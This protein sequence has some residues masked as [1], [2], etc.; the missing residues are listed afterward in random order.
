MFGDNDKNEFLLYCFFMSSSFYSYLHNFRF[1][2]QLEEWGVN[3]TELKESAITQRIIGWTEDWEKE[4]HQKNRAVAKAMFTNKY[5]NYVFDHADCD[6]KLFMLVR[7]LL[8]SFQG[9]TTEGWWFLLFA[10]TKMLK[11][12]V[13]NKFWRFHLFERRREWRSDCGNALPW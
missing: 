5:K 11:M 8:C 3:A 9:K 7:K 1:E 13:W 12:R 4:L 6:N 2:P 10:M